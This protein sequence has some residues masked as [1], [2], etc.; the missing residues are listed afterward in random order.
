MDSLH[1]ATEIYDLIE[2]A[3]AATSQ[4]EYEKYYDLVFDELERLNAELRIKNFLHGDVI[5]TADIELYGLLIRFDVIYFFAYRLNKKHIK[6]YPNIWEYL[7]RLHF[8]EKLG[9]TTDI[10]KIK[11]DYYLGLDEVHNPYH[12]VAN[13]PELGGV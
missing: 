13:G 12:L 7:E 2:K 5:T 10:E 1:L 6:D 8:K 4:E 11:E 3:G 9:K